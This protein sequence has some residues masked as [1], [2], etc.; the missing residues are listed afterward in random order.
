MTSDDRKVLVLLLLNMF[1]LILGG[2]VLSANLSAV[3]HLDAAL[4]RA[5]ELQRERAIQIKL[6]QEVSEKRFRQ[7]EEIRLGVEQLR[8]DHLLMLRKEKCAPAP[9]PPKPGPTPGPAP[10]PP[11]P[12]PPPAPVQTFD[13]A[14]IFFESADLLTP[15]QVSILYGK[16]MA[17][18]LNA[19]TALKPDGKT[20]EW[21]VWDQHDKDVAR[22]GTFFATAQATPRAFLPRL[23]LGDAAGALILDTERPASVAATIKL[24]DQN[25]TA[26]HAQQEESRAAARH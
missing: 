25:K 21:G 22:Q 8:V 2:A 18:Y 23:V 11:K 5:E 12:A 24:L 10:A 16:R 13:R 26:R 17:D 19:A 7:V 6:L 1:L 9:A 15:S 3:N 14:A 4:E 20:H